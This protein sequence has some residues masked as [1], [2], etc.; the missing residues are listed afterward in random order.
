MNGKSAFRMVVVIIVLVA[1][2]VQLA[3]CGYFMHPERRGQPKGNIDAGVAVLDGLGLLLFLIPGI[4]AFAV[5][6]SHN[7]IYLPPGKSSLNAPEKG[8]LLSLE[9]PGDQLTEEQIERIVSQH[10]GFKID[11]DS[12][13]V[14]VYKADN[15]DE[16]KDRIVF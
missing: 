6:F 12:P 15:I 5:D 7:T 9:I 4:I 3:G 8:E 11:L 2:S 13:D 16:I 14:E 10:F 1:M